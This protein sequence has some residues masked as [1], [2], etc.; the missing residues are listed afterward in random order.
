MKELSSHDSEL[1]K[2]LKDFGQELA[3][4][5]ESIKLQEQE[6]K[7]RSKTVYFINLVHGNNATNGVRRKKEESANKA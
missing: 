3:V 2:S 5:T 6:F 7:Y 1:R 4:S